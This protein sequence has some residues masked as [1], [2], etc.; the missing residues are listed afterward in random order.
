MVPDPRS[1]W[2]GELLEVSL[3]HLSL[4]HLLQS[5]R[6]FVTEPVLQEPLDDGSLAHALSPQEQ[7]PVGD[8]APLPLVPAHLAVLLLSHTPESALSVLSRLEER[9]VVEMEA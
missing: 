6:V 8:Q 1:T 4:V 9:E 5:G 2:E 3:V 7:D